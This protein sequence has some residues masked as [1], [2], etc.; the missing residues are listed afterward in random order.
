MASEQVFLNQR[1]VG[2][3]SD[4]EK[5]QRCIKDL[6]RLY[7]IYGFDKI[8]VTSQRS[9][10][11]MNI[12]DCSEH[13]K[14][15]IEEAEDK[16]FNNLY[17]S[18]KKMLIKN[19]KLVKIIANSLIEKKVLNKEDIRNIYNEYLNQKRSKKEYSGTFSQLLYNK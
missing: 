8:N 4:I 18:T 11:E 15:I 7:G 16:L 19:K 3:C 17:E 6:V 5:A 13:K 12:D 2:S 9:E 1:T 14:R 10:Y